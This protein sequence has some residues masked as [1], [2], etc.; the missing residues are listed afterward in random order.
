LVTSVDGRRLMRLDSAAD[1]ASIAEPWFAPPGL[2]GLATD[3]GLGK[4]LVAGRITS[5]LAAIRSV[6]AFRRDGDG[7]GGGVDGGWPQ[8]GMSLKRGQR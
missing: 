8:A 2:I 5:H 4:A 6:R 7:D 3:V 1:S